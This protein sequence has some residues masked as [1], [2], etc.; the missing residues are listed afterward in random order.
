MSNLLKIDL[1]ILDSKG[2]PIKNINVRTKYVNGISFFDEKT[3]NFGYRIATVS[4]GRSF[5]VYVEKPNGEME[6]VKTLNS[7]FS[8]KNIQKIFI[9]KAN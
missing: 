8:S 4:E 6:Y 7:N 2:I 5:E 1:L 9:G 3:N